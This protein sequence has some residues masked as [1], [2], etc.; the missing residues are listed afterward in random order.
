MAVLDLGVLQQ[1][2][3]PTDLFDEPANRF[4]AG[5]VG[6]SNFIEG[7]VVDGAPVVRFASTDAGEIRIPMPACDWPVGADGT[8][9]VRPH[10]ARMLAADDGPP[11]D[12]DSLAWLDGAIDSSEFLGEFVRYRVIVGRLPLIVDQARLAG[13]PIR[14]AGT[15]VRLRLEPGQLRFFPS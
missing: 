7:R 4:V 10:A 5:F 3:A 1:V 11:A 15:R 9:A 2:G 6:T 14:R 12:A 13:R 8:I